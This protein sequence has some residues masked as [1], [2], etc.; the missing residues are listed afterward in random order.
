M[1]G[2]I[3]IFRNGRLEL[4]QPV[5]WPEGTQVE[6]TPLAAPASSPRSSSTP[7]TQWPEGYLDR[8]HADWGGE[9][10]ERPPQGESEV[11]EPW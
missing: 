11:R 9:P 6:V 1:H 5:N 8:L 4:A 7:L 10:F 3:A 2:V